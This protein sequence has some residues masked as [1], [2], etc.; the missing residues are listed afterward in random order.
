MSS[1]LG[2]IP[3]WDIINKVPGDIMI[4]PFLGSIT[5]MF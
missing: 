3:I 4:I 2:S 5:A 1:K